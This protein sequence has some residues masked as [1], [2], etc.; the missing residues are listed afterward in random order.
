VTVLP[1]IFHTIPNSTTKSTSTAFT[2]PPPILFLVG[3]S[4]ITDPPVRY[5]SAATMFLRRFGLGIDH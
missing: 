5:N 2:L 3:S 4:E 1:D